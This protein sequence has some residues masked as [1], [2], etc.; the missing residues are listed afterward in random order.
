MAHCYGQCLFHFF[1]IDTGPIVPIQIVINRLIVRFRQWLLAV[2]LTKKV[3]LLR[4]DSALRTGAPSEFPPPTAVLRSYVQCELLISLSGQLIESCISK[5]RIASGNN[6]LSIRQ[7]L[8]NWKM[9]SILED[10]ASVPTATTVKSP[11]NS[12]ENTSKVA[13][14]GGQGSSTNPRPQRC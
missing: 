4:F 11:V 9:D 6:R 12:S 3:V 5:A 1:I 13:T 14:D 2:R 8:P 10:G 7:N